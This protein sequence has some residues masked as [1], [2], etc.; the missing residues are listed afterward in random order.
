MPVRPLLNKLASVLCSETA[1][2]VLIDRLAQLLGKRWRFLTPLVERYRL[3]FVNRVRPRRREVVR[4]L[5]E[6]RAF[7]K[8][9]RRLQ[10]GEWLAEPPPMEPVA[11]AAGW[12]LPRIET[13]GDLAAWLGVTPDQLDWFADLKRLNAKAASP[14]LGHYHYRIFVKR[15]GGLRLVEAPKRR[16]KEMQRRVLLGILEKIPPHQAAHGF[17][18]G[19]SIHSFIAPHVKQ[20][21]VLRMD[22]SNFF[23]SVIAARIQTFFRAA[24]YPETVAD[25]LGG[26]CTNAVPKRLWRDAAPGMDREEIQQAR[27]LYA[28]RHLPQGAPTSPGLSNIC[29]YRL[30]C[31]LAGLARAAG[32][33]YSRYAD[34]LAFSG[35]PDFARSA[36]RFSTHVAAIL[37]EEGFAAHHR[38]TRIMRPGVRQHLAGITLNETPNIT[39]TDFDLLKAT[40]T[41]CLRHGPSTQNHHGLPHFRM[42]LEGRVA[43]AESVN[44]AKGAKLRALAARIDWSGYVQ[45]LN[46]SR[47][48]AGKRVTPRERSN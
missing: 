14:P 26:I 1:S 9:I 20:Q 38:K 10:A 19:R 47:G 5:L 15:S 45:E 11:A 34:D 6:D 18:K 43:F 21:V 29:A 28:R 48:L 7:R 31:R 17:V 25:L 24:G 39:R 32:A 3:R 35:G 27:I 41:N 4:F 30:D 16:L 42:H 40:L 23:P 37:R 36:E 12:D 33:N 13:A 8:R 2:D 46:T 22:V 44:P